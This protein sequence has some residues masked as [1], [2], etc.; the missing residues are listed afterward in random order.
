M[1]EDELDRTQVKLEEAL[2]KLEEA[3]KTADES[4]RYT[5]YI[6]SAL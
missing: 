2:A 1:I 6:C 5:K 4:E 3:T